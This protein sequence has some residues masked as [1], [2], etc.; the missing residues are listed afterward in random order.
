[1]LNGH[2]WDR[3]NTRAGGGLSAILGDTADLNVGA[4]PQLVERTWRVRMYET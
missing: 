2:A 4:D 1:M 3:G